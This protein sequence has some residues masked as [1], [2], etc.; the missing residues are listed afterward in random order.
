[1]SPASSATRGGRLERLDGGRAR[2]AV[3]HGQLAED[4]AGAQLGQRDRAAVLVLAREL[5]DAG[6]HHV[7]RVAVVALAEDHLAPVVA[8]G[9]RHLRDLIEL[10]SS[11]PAK[12]STCARAALR[13]PPRSAWRA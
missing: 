13:C 3:E 12:T 4:R 9:H 11:S 8:A 6:A 5:T 10:A 7:A 2:L 1:M